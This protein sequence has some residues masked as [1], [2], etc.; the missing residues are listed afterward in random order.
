[1]GLMSSLSPNVFWWVSPRH[2]LGVDVVVVVA[3]LLH[4]EDDVL[5][6]ERDVEPRDVRRGNCGGEV[7]ERP[8]GRAGCNRK[9]PPPGT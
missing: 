1:M 5:S 9:T 3:A 2:V 4:R 7:G 8:V 6:V